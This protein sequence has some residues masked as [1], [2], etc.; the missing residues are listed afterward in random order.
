[1][2]KNTAYQ[3]RNLNKSVSPCT[4]E[5]RIDDGTPEYIMI[6]EICERLITPYDNESNYTTS[7]THT[8]LLFYHP[9]CYDYRCPE[10]CYICHKLIT[11]Y[12]PELV[13]VSVK[14]ECHR[15]CHDIQ[16]YP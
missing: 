13:Y 10:P 3:N 9:T 8:Q 4:P 12:S 14:G 5:I 11:I 6:C 15:E 1:M 16:T 2:K 7:E